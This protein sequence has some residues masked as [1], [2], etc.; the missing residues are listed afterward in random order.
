MIALSLCGETGRFSGKSDG[1]NFTLRSPA[2]SQCSVRVDAGAPN[3]LRR[4]A[5]HAL[6][7]AACAS[8]WA[9]GSGGGDT[10]PITP[11]PAVTPTIAISNSAAISG[12]QGSTQTSTIMLTRG[13]NYTG[14]VT[15]A[16]SGAPSGV[17]VT[18]NPSTLSG[19]TTTSTVS[20]VIGGTAAPTT[21][22]N[23]TVTATGTGVS[24]ATTSVPLTVVAA[25]SPDFTLSPATANATVIQGQSS[26]ATAFTLARLN[27]YSG[28][29]QLTASN[30]PTGVTV[31]F[32]QPGAGSAGGVVF[33]ALSNTGTGTYPITIT[34]SGPNTTA[35]TAV[36]TLV[37]QATPTVVVG[38]TPPTLSLAQGAAGQTAITISRTNITGDVTLT[39][40]NVPQGVTATFSP[41]AT[42]GTTSSL[43]LAVGGAVTPGVYTITVR[44]SA[45]GATAGTA[46]VTLTV[47]AAQSYT[48]SATSAS[49]QQSTSGTSTVTI[50]RS[51]GF[52][53]AVTLAASNLPN[54]VTAAFAP[55]PTTGTS[56]TL[57]LSASGAATPGTYSITIT[58][59]A[60]G[61]AN[62]T[63]T[64]SVSVTA[65]GGGSGNINWTFCDTDDF[66][67]WFAAQEGSGAWT[68]ITPSGT[69]T[70]IYSFNMSGNGGVAYAQT[71]S[72]GGVSVTVQYL[73]QDELAYGSTSEC[74]TNPA[75][76]NLTGTVAGLSAGQSASV[77]VGNGSGSASLN[78]AISVTGVPLGVTDL[79]A[80]RSAFNL[81]TLSLA[82]D[83]AILRRNVNF[84]SAIAPT[85]DFAGGDSF[86]LTSALYTIANG[87][88][89]PLQVTTGYLTT[90]GTAGNFVSALNTTT[91]P[92]TVYGVPSGLTQ[93]GDLHQILAFAYTTSGGNTTSRGI[94]QYNRD[95]VARTVTLGAA[96]TNPTLSSLGSAPYVRYSATGSWQSDYPHSVGVGYTK[97]V[98]GSNAWTLTVSRTYAGAG[99]ST[100]SLVMPDFSGVAGFNTAWGMGTGTANVSIT[101]SGVSSGFNTGTGIWSEGGFFRFASRTT[102]ISP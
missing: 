35:K 96:L 47:T 38:L 13:G 39:A 14:A 31:L 37:V 58:G 19:A 98:S 6:S 9:C 72:S 63:T 68:R 3:H 90:N 99:A 29:V 65:G 28:D 70:R 102:T 81:T 77:M 1:S 40:E 15:L 30:L 45:A 42:A 4:L 20:A 60:A 10:P 62:V 76:K 41:S 34:A 59:T 46:T 89:E 92:V 71:L 26:V 22:G 5:L 78:G 97:S 24:S 86:A 56:S 44:G 48:L 32:T 27:S 95:L 18:L 66:P 83:R 85:L 2:M 73:S 49:V 33:T 43:A 82:P 55:N 75:K 64:A 100:Y 50:T 54:G 11:P 67:L 93:S 51:G 88:G 12:Q 101:A 80:T 74:V 53:G 84:A 52:A 79:L 91:N 94:T 21:T 7:L 61:V 16:A 8:I 69:T 23:I 57:T 17:T 25:P 87:N 36:V